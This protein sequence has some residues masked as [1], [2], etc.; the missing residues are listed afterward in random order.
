M[1]AVYSTFLLGAI[2]ARWLTI[3]LTLAAFVAALFLLRYVPQQFFPSSDR[4]E[5]TVGMTLRQN[6]SIYATEAQAK[7][8][9]AFLSHR[10]NAL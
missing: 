6:A 1:V 7:R 2:R 4:S 8:L 5:L 9:E 10:S 3:A